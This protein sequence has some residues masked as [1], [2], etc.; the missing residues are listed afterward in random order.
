MPDVAAQDEEVRQVA[1]S[2]QSDGA[3]AVTIASGYKEV[4]HTSFRLT[5]TTLT[6]VLPLVGHH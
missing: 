6:G 3:Y 5:H 2:L 4:Q 1:Q